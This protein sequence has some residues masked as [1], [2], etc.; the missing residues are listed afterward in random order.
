MT[1]AWLDAPLMGTRV[2]L[3]LVQPGDETALVGLMTDPEVRR[4]IGGP[5][6]PEEARASIH[7]DDIWWGSFVVAQV[8]DDE[9]VGT[10]SFARKRG[11]WEVS[12]QLRADLWGQGLMSEAMMLAL[13]WFFASQDESVCIAVTQDANTRTRR[14]LERSG[15][16]LTAEFEQYGLP[17]LQYEFRPA[18]SGRS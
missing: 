11:P 15:G 12:F 2:M 13:T 4:Y 14:L 16:V 8:S 9:V 6:E 5:R 1:N 18:H 10:L 3:R 7:L 17:Q